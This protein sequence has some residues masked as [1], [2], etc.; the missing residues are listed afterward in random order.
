ML[1]VDLKDICELAIVTVEDEDGMLIT[2]GL[3]DPIVRDGGLSGR[4]DGAGLERAYHFTTRGARDPDEYKNP[5]SPL[6]NWLR[7]ICK[8]MHHLKHRKRGLQ[9]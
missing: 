8:P 2:S 6:Q 7:A 9:L 5:H 4:V 1:F 3:A